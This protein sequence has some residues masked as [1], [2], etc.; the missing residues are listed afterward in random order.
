[1]ILPLHILIATASIFSSASAFLFPSKSKLRL[2]YALIALT[3]ISGF[4]LMWGKPVHMA[5]VCT[6]GLIYLGIV[7]AGIFAARH[8]LAAA[9]RNPITG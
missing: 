2:T 5:Q 1:M 8:K 6:T 3:F 9:A 7:S 4:F